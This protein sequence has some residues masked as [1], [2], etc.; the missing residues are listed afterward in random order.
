MNLPLLK[1]EKRG[2]TTGF[3]GVN[4]K[5]PPKP[6]AFFNADAVERTQIKAGLSEE[7]KKN[8]HI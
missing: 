3:L 7:N 2:K 4:A 6:G 1:K 8:A 5:E